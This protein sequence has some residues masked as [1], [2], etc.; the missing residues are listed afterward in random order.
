MATKTIT[1][2]EEAYDRLK[3]L[4]N[5]RS[6]S[7]LIMDIT[8]EEDPDL[9]KSFGKWNEEEVEKARERIERLRE[10][11]DEEIHG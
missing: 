6:F 11:V 7:E 2:K 1:V 10:N 8:E 4:K 9:W 3:A 5:D